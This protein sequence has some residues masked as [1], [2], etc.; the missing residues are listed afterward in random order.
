V[1]RFI[2][3][4]V[5][6]VVA[7]GFQKP[8][9]LGKDS[10]APDFSAITVHGDT[11]RLSGLKGSI[12]YVDFWASWC[13]PCRKQ[14]IALVKLQEKFRVLSKRTGLPLVFISI[15][16]DTN[17]DLWRTAMAKDNLSWKNQI[18]D[19]NGWDSPLAKAYQIRKIP[20][21]FLIGTGGKII[22]SDI[23]GPALDEALEKLYK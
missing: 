12:V 17:Q 11:I 16:M 7:A 2:I 13:L 20:T 19:G 23:W 9:A 5:L 3:F 14:N 10:Q 8:D 18:C 22:A 21:S 6:F 4:S 15:S 1:F